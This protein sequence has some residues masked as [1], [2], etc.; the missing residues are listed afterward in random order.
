MLRTLRRPAATLL[1]AALALAASVTDAAEVRDRAGMFSPEAA[2][3]AESELTRV[4]KRAGTP[5]FIET[6]DAIPGLPADAD[7]RAKLRAINELAQKRGREVDAQGVY[8]LLSGKDKVLSNVLVRERHAAALPEAARRKIRDA[9][10][11]PFK[12][13][14]YDAGLTSA[15]AAID[16]AL[17]GGPVAAR[18]GDGR[19]MV[20]VAP[21]PGGAAA[22][23]QRAGGEQQFGLGTLLVIGGGILGVL[24][25]VRLLSGSLG[26]RGGYPQGMGRAGMGGP[27][28]GPGMGGP[29]MGPGM[30]GPGMMGGRGGGFFSGMLGGL[31][32]AMAGNWLYD[33]FSGRHSSPGHHADASSPPPTDAGYTGGDG[34]VGGDDAGHGASWGDSGGGDWGDSG[35]DW[36]GGDWG[37]GDDG[38]SW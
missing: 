24:F 13:G 2:R 16:S 35:G 21:A 33:Q 26:N 38:G 34:F 6:I 25:I 17:P 36:G 10:I 14:D 29:G 37:G 15:V 4:E 18:R 8:I 22:A 5:I 23:N 28:M 30:G 32:G 20:P 9:F 3:K 31:G 1:A 7:S 11:E 27:G 19:R 12:A